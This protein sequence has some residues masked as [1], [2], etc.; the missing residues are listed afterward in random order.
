MFNREDF[1]PSQVTSLKQEDE[2]VDKLL[3]REQKNYSDFL[4]IED[5]R[6][7]IRIFPPHPGPNPSL[8]VEPR[9]TTQLP[10]LYK[11]KDQN[12]NIIMENGQPKMIERTKHIFNSKVHGSLPFDLVEEY[13]SRVQKKSEEL[14]NNNEKSRVDYLKYIYGRFNRKDRSQNIFGINYS[15]KWV[16]Y[17]KKINDP[18]NPS[19]FQYGRLE[20]GKSIKN[21]LNEIAAIESENQ[22]IT[23]DP[24]SDPDEGITV[25]IT[26]NKDAQQPSEFYRTELYMPRMGSS[27]FKLFPLSDDDLKWLSEQESLSSMYQNSFKRKDLDFQIKGL[28]LLDKKSGYG[29]LKD[30]S[31]IKL[32]EEAFE[33][34]PEEDTEQETSSENIKQ[35]VIQKVEEKTEI[36]DQEQKTTLSEESFVETVSTQDRLAKLR[37]KFLGNSNE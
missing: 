13:I 14:Y 21:R 15:Q 12:G 33:L 4:R 18:D 11:E 26:F 24:F 25:S 30:P 35:E 32:I 1:K 36:R 31:F 22:A 17:V 9:V 7:I 28:E 5:G 19:S 2:K 3:G 20:I 23:T 16:M 10:F 27:S 8:F 6:N 29:I 34:M 37:S